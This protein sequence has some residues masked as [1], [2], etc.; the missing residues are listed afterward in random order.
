MITGPVFD[1]LNEAW[2]KHITAQM[3]AAE[4]M[5][6]EEYHGRRLDYLGGAADVLA[7][8]MT[9]VGTNAA[10]DPGGKLTLKNFADTFMQLFEDTTAQ[11]ENLVQHVGN[12]DAL[13]DNAV[14]DK[15]QSV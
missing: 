8:L 14:D 7:V 10:K 4:P 3:S 5:Q 9:Q 11:L 13:S 15:P 12:E 1:N 6:A 2:D